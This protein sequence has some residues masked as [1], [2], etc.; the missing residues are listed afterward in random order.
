M[1][2]KPPEDHGEFFGY[3]SVVFITLLA[4]IARILHRLVTGN[5][6]SLL[7]AFAQ[8]LMSILASALILFISM[9]IR[10]EIAETVVA[11][12][13]A[14]WSGVTVVIMLEKKFLSRLTSEK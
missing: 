6:Y 2:F 1:P 7:T 11:C 10:L 3:F 4:A 9:H 13:L 5:R 8:I 12:G 14:S